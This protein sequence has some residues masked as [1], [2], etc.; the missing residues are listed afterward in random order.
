MAAN[1]IRVENL[2][3]SGNVR[4]PE[5]GMSIELYDDDE[6]VYVY[7]ILDEKEARQLAYD[8]L[9]FLGVDCEPYCYDEEEE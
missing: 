1:S 9:N 8:I 2:H 6:T 5:R 7:K 4:H 3:V